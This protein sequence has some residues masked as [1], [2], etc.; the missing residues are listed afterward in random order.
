MRDNNVRIEKGGVRD[1]GGDETREDLLAEGRIDNEKHLF[2]RD[3]CPLFKYKLLQK[4]GQMATSRIENALML[5]ALRKAATVKL[6]GSS[7]FP[8]VNS[9]SQFGHLYPTIKENRLKLISSA[10][11]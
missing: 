4:Y 7:G 3:I 9:L 10:H 1:F 2:L 11:R 5:R 8:A 6:E